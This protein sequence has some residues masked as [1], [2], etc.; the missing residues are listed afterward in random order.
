MRLFKDRCFL[1]T[2]ALAPLT[3]AAP[4]LGATEAISESAYV[5]RLLSLQPTD[6]ESQPAPAT[7]E[8]RA[9]TNPDPEDICDPYNT[10]WV[11]QI[12]PLMWYVSPSGELTLPARS[13]SGGS[14]GGGFS[15]SGD[16]VRLSELNLDSPQFEPAGDLQVSI[17]RFRVGFSG[18][19]N[20][21]T[22]DSTI[23]DEDFRLGAVEIAAGDELAV[24]FELTTVQLTLGYNVWS[25][26]FSKHKL[27]HDETGISPIALRLYAFG[28]IRLYETDISVENLST[29]ASA[30]A[31]ETFFEPIIGARAE[32]QIARPFT[33]DVEF[34]GGFYADSD[35][36]ASSFDVAVGFM[37]HPHPNVGIQLGWR[38]LA[39]SL[40][41][42]EDDSVSEFD[43]T[44]RLAGLYTGI[45]LRF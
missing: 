37:Y 21:V 35:R 22:R 6:A 11:I 1:F 36:S 17:D 31:S 23:A 33:I 40:S 4:A 38:Q 2:A 24:D 7:P 5:S 26:D 41:D 44:G 9:N 20:S 45:T 14:T 28:G 39:F 34:S 13:G 30:E 27:E 8:V 10:G 25:T 15:D 18:A 43:Y 42:G 19:T 32:L 16:S 29:A 3:L 12:E